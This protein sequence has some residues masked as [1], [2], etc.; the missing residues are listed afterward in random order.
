MKKVFAFV[1]VAAAIS[2]ASCGG[3]TKTEG[4]DSVKVDSM[5]VDTTAK[6][7]DTTA[8]VD[9]TAKADTTKK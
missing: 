6:T 2:F 3:E 9:T 7:V 8:V 1:V 5:P 4:T